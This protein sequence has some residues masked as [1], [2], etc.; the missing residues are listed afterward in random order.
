MISFLARIISISI[1]IL[2]LLGSYSHKLIGVETLH[3]IHIV[4]IMQAF[5]PRYR[6]AVLYFSEL[7][8]STN[9]FQSLLTTSTPLSSSPYQQLN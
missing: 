1:L 8:S 2:W 6:P 9:F 5:A 3:A 7:H 4:F